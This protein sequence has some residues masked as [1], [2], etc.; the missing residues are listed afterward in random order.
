MKVALTMF[1]MVSSLI[2]TAQQRVLRKS[3]DDNGRKLVVEIDLDRAG[4]AVQYR[5]RFDVSQLGKSE[6]QALLDHVLDSLRLPRHTDEVAFLD[7]VTEEPEGFHPARVS[8]PP[9]PPRLRRAIAATAPGAVGT[10][11]ATAS[12]ESALTLPESPSEP[13]EP[14]S[15]IVQDLRPEGKMRIYCEFKRNGEVW[16]VERLLDVRGKSEAEKERLIEETQR[17]FSQ[18]LMPASF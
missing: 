12:S 1:F 4:Q 13:T 18:G 9:A 7:Q 3:I 11:V 8:P 10:G 17:L 16:K 5:G 14:L 6:K 2:A 15:Q